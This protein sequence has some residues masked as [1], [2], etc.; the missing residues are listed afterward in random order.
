LRKELNVSPIYWDFTRRRNDLSPAVP[1]RG[2]HAVPADPGGDAKAVGVHDLVV[3]EPIGNQPERVKHADIAVD[4]PGRGQRH[5]SA[6][7]VQE[8]PEAQRPEQLARKRDRPMHEPD[9][10][11][12]AEHHGDI[13]DELE[14][15]ERECKAG[16]NDKIKRAVNAATGTKTELSLIGAPP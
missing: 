14:I 8:S 9:D 15:A 10:K 5:E 12:Q 4:R 7:H 2:A 13:E 11:D 1:D 16:R 3:L 6:G